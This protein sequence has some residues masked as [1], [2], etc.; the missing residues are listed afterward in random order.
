MIEN[1]ISSMAA[2]LVTDSSFLIAFIG[3]AGVIVGSLTTIVGNIIIEWFKNKSQKKLDL[4]RQ[5]LLKE[6]LLDQ[7]YQWRSI[8]TLSAVIGCSE[9]QTKN[10]LIAISARGSELNDGK[11]GLIS[12]HPLSE[13]KRDE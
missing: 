13:I 8:S 10:H 4:A 1:P 9:E 11:W 6:L 7:A 3:F 5:K 12:R 2:R